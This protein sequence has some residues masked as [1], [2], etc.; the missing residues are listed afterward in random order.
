MN[1]KS[2]SSTTT[3]VHLLFSMAN[4]LAPNEMPYDVVYLDSN[5]LQRPSCL[6]H[7]M[8]RINKFAIF[9]TIKT[10]PEVRIHDG[11]E[12]FQHGVVAERVHADDV[13]VT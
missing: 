13:E 2:I 12:D 10:Y 11:R 5:C 9:L 4:S 3:S 7:S 1:A 8:V 6:Q